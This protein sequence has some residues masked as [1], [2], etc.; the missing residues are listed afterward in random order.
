MK[1]LELS[2]EEIEFMQ[3]ILTKLDVPDYFEV[4]SESMQIKIDALK[5]KLIGIRSQLEYLKVRKGE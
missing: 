4:I 2:Y 1:K 3:F 5:L